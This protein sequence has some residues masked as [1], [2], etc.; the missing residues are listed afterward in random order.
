MTLP[1]QFAS[2]GTSHNAFKG[3]CLKR[4]QL[5]HF[6]GSFPQ[7]GPVKTLPRE[8]ASKGTSHNATKGV[9]LKREQA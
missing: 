7:E 6:E 4:D 5:R 8:F 9:C 3:V 1:R 2:R